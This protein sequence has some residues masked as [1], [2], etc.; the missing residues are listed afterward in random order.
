MPPAQKK[1]SFWLNLGLNV[2]LPALILSKGQSALENALKLEPDSI[3]PL[4][5]FCVALAFPFFYG[6]LDLIKRKKWNIFSI[7]GVLNVFLTGTVGLFELSREWIIA[8]EAGIPAI[9]GLLVLGSAYTSK[10]LARVLIY[11]DA[12]LDVKMLDDVLEKKGAKTEFQK[13]LKASTILIAASF[14]VSALIQFF[15]A[16]SIFTGKTSGSEFN[17]Q[18]GKMT[19]VSYIAVL[20]PCMIISILALLKI[21]KDLKRLTGLSLEESLAEELRPKG[22]AQ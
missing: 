2:V 5:I 19:W 15:L 13:S 21:F 4:A 12:L 8:K 22:G 11:N 6:I 20:G 9:L 1:E 14:F 3:P 10:P 17:E 18:V 7:F 16:A